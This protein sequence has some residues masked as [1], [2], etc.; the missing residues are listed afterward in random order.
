MIEGALIVF[1]ILIIIIAACLLPWW[2][3]PV[4][5]IVGIIWSFFNPKYH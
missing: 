1:S 5:F 2:F 3:F 4:M